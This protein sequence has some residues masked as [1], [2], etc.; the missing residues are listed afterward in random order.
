MFSYQQQKLTADAGVIFKYWWQ[1]FCYDSDGYEGKQIAIIES[2][3]VI[4]LYH[5]P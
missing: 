3:Q 4:G 5:K 2:N 1:P